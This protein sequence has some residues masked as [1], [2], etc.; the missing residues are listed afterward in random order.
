MDHKHIGLVMGLITLSAFAMGGCEH[1][2]PVSGTQAVEIVIPADLETYK[3]EMTE[4]A[5]VGGDIHPAD[6][7]D[8]ITETIDSSDSNR[9]HASAV[10]AAKII[11]DRIEIEYFKVQNRTVYLRSNFHN[12]GFA[13]VSVYLAQVEPVLRKTLLNYTEIDNLVFDYAPSK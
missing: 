12:D 2:E 13:G 4:F 1:H 6:R 10:I 3:T 8:F 11:D 7:M 9:I 5:Q